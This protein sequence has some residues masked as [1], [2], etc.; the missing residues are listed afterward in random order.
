M[1]LRSSINGNLTE[2]VELHEDILGELHRAVPHS[3]YTQ[4]EFSASHLKQPSQSH[5]R[6]RS[7]DAVPENRDGMSW[8]SA[9]PGMVA[10]PQVAAEVA[11]IFRKKVSHPGGSS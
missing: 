6:I 1:G 10:D 3:E 8:L 9:V 5:R 7:L 2:I 11:K 4:M